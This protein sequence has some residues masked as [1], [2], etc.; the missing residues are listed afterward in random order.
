MDNQNNVEVE[1]ND[2]IFTQQD[3]SLVFTKALVYEF[4]TP[5]ESGEL[6]FYVNKENSQILY[7][8]ND[9]MIDAVVSYPNGI[10]TIYG[11]KGDGD[12]AS[13]H[14]KIEFVNGEIQNQNSLQPIEKSMTIDQSHI[15]MKTIESKGFKI[16]YEKTNE[17][18]T[19]FI[20]SQIPINARQIYGFAALEG[21]AKTP[22][23][24]NFLNVLHN[25]QLITYIESKYFKIMLLDYGEN[26][27]FFSLRPYQNI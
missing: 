22:V 2:F 21:D 7:K 17:H 23:D 8:P 12:F 24:F 26:P 13:I 27:Y 20:T 25:H 6:W 5:T 9:D 19:V 18:E 16:L 4:T 1:Q 10:Y 11:R 3:S 14:Q 15:G